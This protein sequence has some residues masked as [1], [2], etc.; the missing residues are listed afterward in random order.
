MKKLL[1]FLSILFCNSLSFATQITYPT[2]WA[3][4]DTV[5]NTK[6]N[7]NGN[8]VSNVV[9]GNLDNTNMAS[10]YSLFQTVAVLPTAGTQGRVD[11]LTSDSSLN[12]DNGSS[13][14]KTITPSGTPTTGQIP[15]YNSGWQLFTPGTSGLPIVSNGVSSLPTY[16]TLNLS[17]GVTGNLSV[18]NLN[19]GT[20]ASSSTFW[21]GDSTWAGSSFIPNNIQVFTSSGTW[22]KPAGVS[23][24]Y[25]KLWGA[26]GGTNGIDGGGGGGSY[27]EGTTAVSGNVSITVGTGGTAGSHNSPGTDGGD[28]IFAGTTTI[29]AGGGK[30]AQTAGTASNGS[31]NLSGQAGR[32]TSNKD[33]GD[34]ALGGASGG[35]SDATGSNRLIGHFPGGGGAGC[36]GIN[37][38]ETGGGGANGLVIVYY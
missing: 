38:G 4:N 12:L 32:S 1:I 14:L 15:Y 9:N 30:A 25:V 34:S 31:I 5:T 6:L 8:A 24:V 17:T 2:V 10:G 20:S 35:W 28:S 13:W 11:F 36:T 26:G 3:V 16:Q 22:T 23:N 27:S 19:S 18:N 21:R 7:N 37:S 29:T 33:G